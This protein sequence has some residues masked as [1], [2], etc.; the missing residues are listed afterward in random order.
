MQRTKLSRRLLLISATL[1]VLLII[2]MVKV[3]LMMDRMTLAAH[4]INEV[5]VPQLQLI[6]EVELNVTRASL[7][8]RHAILA[9][10]DRELSEALTDVAAKKM[11]LLDRL[12]HFG[13]AMMDEEERMAFRPLPALMDTFWKIGEENVALIQ[14]G[15]RE[16]AFAFLV[17]KT[18]PARNALL[19]PLANEKKRQGDRLAFRV[20][21]IEESSALTHNLIVGTVL[22]VALGLIGL[23]VYLGR[24]TRQLGADPDELRRVADNVSAGDLSIHIPVSNGDQTSAMAALRSMTANLATSVSAVRQGAESVSSASTEIATGNNDLSGRTEHQ[25]STL[26]QTAASIKE[27]DATVN[28]NAQSAQEATRRAQSAAGLAQQ[29]GSVMSDVVSTMHGIQ[30]SSRQIADII[31]VIDGIAFQTNILALNAAVEAARAGEQGRGFA[32]VAGEVRTLAQRSAEAAKQI[33]QLIDTS[34]ERVQRGS[35]LVERAGSNMQEIVQAIADVS[36]IM[37]EIST[38]SVEQGAGTRQI[39]E[40]VMQMDQVTQ[41]NAALVE[42]IAAAASSLRT[43]ASELLRAV[44]VFKLVG[45]LPAPG[46]Q[47]LALSA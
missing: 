3:W 25:A 13:K 39:S 18:I 17:D 44:S 30:D 28:R 43:Q 37:Q 10:N 45:N 22:F 8:L 6:A 40:A 16:E 34:A 5:N 31:G 21:E 2:T 42:E 32:V 47:R 35:A 14:A 24:V 20:N 12:Q 1:V 29:G 27:L 26:Q 9:R 7:Q 11:L 23:S 38:A 33:K 41:Q 4:R 46:H 15:R 19:T 36:G